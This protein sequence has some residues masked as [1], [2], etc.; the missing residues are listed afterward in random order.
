VSGHLPSGL[1]PELVEP[2]LRGSFGRPYAYRERVATTQAVA[3]RLPHGGVAACEEQTAGRGR[4]GRRWACPHGR[5]ILFSLS[6]RPRTP[7][8]RLPPISL[9]VAEAV[10]EALV[11]TAAVRWPNDVVVDGRKLAGVLPE[12]RAG[13]LVIGVGVNANLA[14][15]ELPADARVPAASLALELGRTVDRAA[16]LAD[17][18]E[19]IERAYEAFE[20]DGFAGLGRD[21]LRGRTVE[22]DGGLSG[23]CDG[24]DRDGRLVVAGV[25]HTSAEVR[26]VVVAGEELSPR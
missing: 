9:V 17:L 16:V 22:L 4:L 13:V 3:R 18:L 10:C 6:L 15:H 19:A 14:A 1:A 25:P 2:L 20:R 11:P 7:A 12:L 23:R 21:A 8:E 5:G 24:V 26:R